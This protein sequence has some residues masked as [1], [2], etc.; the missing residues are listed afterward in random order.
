LVVDDQEFFR[1]V[2]CDLVSAT[3][4]FTVV[5]EAACG[6]DALRATDLLSP[7]LVLMDL[8]MPGCGGIQAARL[9]RER[10]RAVVVILVSAH[11]PPAST[12]RELADAKVSFV[13]KRDLC[14]AVLSEV[15]KRREV[16][17]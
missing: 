2:L 12:A 15:W 9:L 13:S 8:R 3:P 6:E 4:G 11:D 14:G 7:E 17:A 5:G 10:H 16:S 1:G